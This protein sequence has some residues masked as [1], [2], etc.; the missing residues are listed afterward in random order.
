MALPVGAIDRHGHQIDF[1]LT[2]KRDA[3]P[4]RAFLRKAIEHGAAASTSYKLHR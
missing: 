2:A 4:A 3:K 1:R